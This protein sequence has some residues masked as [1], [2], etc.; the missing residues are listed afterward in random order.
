MVK[1]FDI[2]IKYAIMAWVLILSGL[3]ITSRYSYLLFHSLAEIFSIVVAFG[4]FMVAWNSRRFLDNSYFL[5]LG[6]AYFFVAAQDLIHT[7]AYQGMGV[8][9]DTTTNLPT[10]LWIAARYTEAISLLIAPLFSD[11]KIEL[12]W[13]FVS[14]GTAFALL[15]SSIFYLDIFPD[16]FVEG[17]GLTTFKKISEYII[18]LILLASIALLI[19]K[20]NRFEKVVLQLL[21]TSLVLTVCSELAFTMYI[22][23]YGLPNLIGHYFKVVSFYLMYRAIIHTGLVRPYSLLFRD[24]KKSE[25]EL[26]KSQARYRSVVEDQTELI[27]RFMPDGTLTFVNKAYC[28]YFGKKREELVGHKFLPLIPDEDHEKIDAHFAS[29][30]PENGVATHEHRVYRPNGEIRWQQ[31]TNRAIYDKHG[32]LKE[33]QAV[34]RDITEGR[35][36][37]NALRESEDKYRSMM[38]AMSDPVYIC[39]PDYRVSYM[40]PAMVKRTGGDFIG[41]PC[42]KV[43]NA[44]DEK[45]PW[46]VFDRVQQGEHH[47][48]EVLSPKDGRFYHISNSPIF[49]T[50]GSISKMTIYTDITQLRRTEKALKEAHNDLEKRV[51]NRT[52]ELSETNVRL[53]QQIAERKLTEEALKS[54]DLELRRVSSQLLNAQEEERRRIAMDLHDGIGQSLSAI[55]FRVETALQE[56]VGEAL[57]KVKKT[58]APVVPVIQEATEEVRRISMD[59]RPSILDDLGI[60]STIS[61]RCRLVEETYPKIQIERE[62]DIEENGVPD[63]LKIVIYRVLL[64]AMNN[65]TKHSQADVVRILLRETGGKIELNISDNG[66]GFDVE[67][68]LS[69]DPPEKGVGISSMKERAELSGGHFSLKSQNGVGTTVRVSWPLNERPLG[70]SPSQGD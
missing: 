57:K 50:D 48:N 23:A 65:V 7:L 54:S 35:R 29:I 63:S 1:L 11:R 44:L 70:S 53:E 19:G 31:W 47:R 45:C 42:Y 25:E 8:F 16:C 43:I 56:M 34:G 14:Y 26:R 28:E 2:S 32:H 22:H 60:L 68:I 38:E 30:S 10:Q 37:E 40:N 66:E 20:R 59:L 49:H 6:I 46:C 17:A 12:K 36:V 58:L 24:L 64:E 4:I 41:E 5:I 21:V 9:P 15:L 67:S 18:S 13:V 52:V 33:F 51:K 62:F 27:C 61:W 69:R 3:Y 55:K 39:S